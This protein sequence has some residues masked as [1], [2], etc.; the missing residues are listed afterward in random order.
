MTHLGE[1]GKGANLFVH[2]FAQTNDVVGQHKVFALY[3]VLAALGDEAVCAVEGN[4]TIVTDDAATAVGIRQTGNDAGGTSGTNAGGVG[5]KHA[6]VVGLAGGLEHVER[7]L[8]HLEA[9]AFQGLLGH[10]KTAEGHEGALQRGICLQTNNC[11]K[12]LIDIACGMGYNGGYHFL[13]CC[14]Y[15]AC[16]NFLLHKQLHLVPQCIC[17][18]CGAGEETLIA[19]V[20]GVVLLNEIAYVDGFSPYAAVKALPFCGKAGCLVCS[21]AHK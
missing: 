6:F 18:G 7:L 21:I 9:V 5:I 4:T 8:A 19:L 17:A 3:Q 15:A 2:F 10:T 13:I 1:F 12:V 16:L 14:K 20:G 11:F